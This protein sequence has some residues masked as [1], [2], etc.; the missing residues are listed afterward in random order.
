METITLA[1]HHYIQVEDQHAGHNLE[2][3]I[4]FFTIVVR[5]HHILILFG[6][7]I[8]MVLFNHLRLYKLVVELCM[9]EHSI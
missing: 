8:Q 7:N 1:L 5:L 9:L 4:N 6:F 3:L 2:V